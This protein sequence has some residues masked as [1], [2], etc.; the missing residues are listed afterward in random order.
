MNISN[1]GRSDWAFFLKGRK[2]LALEGMSCVTARV[3]LRKPM[4]V[5]WG[6]GAKVSLPT[7]LGGDFRKFAFKA[8]PVCGCD[9]IWFSAHLMEQDDL[10][11]PAWRVYCASFPDTE[12]RLRAEHL[13]ALKEPRYRFSAVMRDQSVIGVLGWWN[14]PGFCFV[15]H[16]AIAPEHRAEGLGQRAMR[17]LQEHASEPIVLDVE[18]YGWDALANRRITFYKRLGFGYSAQSVFLPAYD[19]KP[20]APTNFMAWRMPLDEAACG[21]IFHAV[22]R[23]IYKQNA[24]GLCQN[25][26]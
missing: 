14:L 16:F 11:E 15:E 5:K 23:E 7:I 2:G 9:G 20:I 22:T 17:L 25:A 1:T 10:F 13:D 24:F 12:R 19:G 3:H 21:R 4:P 26:V 18:P 8:L 6:T